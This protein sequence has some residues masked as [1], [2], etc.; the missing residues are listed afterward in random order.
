MCLNRILKMLKFYPYLNVKNN[1]KKY[2]FY[3]VP[4]NQYLKNDNALKMHFS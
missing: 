3:R 1:K 2:N 4:P